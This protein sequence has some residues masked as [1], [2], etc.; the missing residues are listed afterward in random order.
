MLIELDDIGFT[1]WCSRI[2][3]VLE[4]TG[5]DQN[6]ESQNIGDTIKFMLSGFKDSIVTIFT[7][8]WREDI[9]SSSKLRTNALVTK[10]SLC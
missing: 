8:R 5:F 3:S 7:Q 2:R 6:R 9:K 1:N 4:R 10:I